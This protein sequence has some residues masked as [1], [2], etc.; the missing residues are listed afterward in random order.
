[1]PLRPLFLGN[2]KDPQDAFPNRQERCDGCLVRLWIARDLAFQLDDC[3]DN[4]DT[5]PHLL[6]VP[7]AIRRYGRDQLREW[8]GERLESV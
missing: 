6:C 5:V 3:F 2:P 8:F 1:M 7:C 4:P